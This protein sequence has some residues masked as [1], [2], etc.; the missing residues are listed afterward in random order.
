MFA[1]RL[2]NDL[3]VFQLKY[4]IDSAE[5][6]YRVCFAD[7]DEC[8]SSPCENGATCVDQDNEYRC[9]CV[10]GYTGTECE[11]GEGDAQKNT[12]EI[13]ISYGLTM[14][15]KHFLNFQFERLNEKHVG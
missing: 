2:F 4:S 13:L 8:E 14:Q 12:G 7:I 15:R 1:E 9:D 6:L 10:D 11:I 5:Y 3:Q